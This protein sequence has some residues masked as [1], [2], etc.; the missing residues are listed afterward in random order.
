VFGALSDS[1]IAEEVDYSDT[2]LPEQQYIEIVGGAGLR[3]V[4]IDRAVAATRPQE[5]NVVEMMLPH[6]SGD[7]RLPKVRPPP[8]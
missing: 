6:R 3:G 1:A 5:G 4:R 7:R 8:R 2:E